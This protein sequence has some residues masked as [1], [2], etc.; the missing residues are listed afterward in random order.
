LL[1]VT[2]ITGHSGSW[3]LERMERAA[4]KIGGMPLPFA[5][6]RCAVRPGSDASRLEASPL[7]IEIARGDLDDIDFLLRSM[8]GAR[9]VLHIASIFTSPNVAEAA[10]RSGVEWLVMV[11]TTGR[12][13]KYK[14]ASEEY[15]RIEE[16]ILSMRDKIGV[17]VLRPTMIYGS[18][19]DRNMWK[20][21]DFLHRHTLF[22]LFGAGA[23]LMQ[24]VH[25]RDLGNAYY[26]VLAN[27]ER[28]FNRDYNLPGKRPISYLDLVRRVSRTLGRRN[29]IVKVPLPLSIL[30]AKLYNAVS[31]TPVISVEQVLRMQED[32]AFDYVDAAR[33]FGYAP[34]SFEEGIVEEV[35]EYLASRTGRKGE[36]RSDG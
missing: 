21:V 35:R 8:R 28:T 4:A 18:S 23:N 6:V 2:G 30:G 31:R 36:A 17:T 7:G 16:A 24:P 9:A 32:K 12:Y 27:R 10:L 14:S 15:I 26:D 13:S 19:R 29:V 25:A 34:L 11:H 33:D 20:L 1:Y 22:P 5:G 3:F